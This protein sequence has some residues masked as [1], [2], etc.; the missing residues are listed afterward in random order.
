MRSPMISRLFV[1]L[2]PATMLLMVSMVTAAVPDVS[3]LRRQPTVVDV[4]AD[5][6]PK[7]E[8]LGT[9][10]VR[11]LLGYTRRILH[12]PDGHRLAFF[13]FSSAAEANWLF[14]LDVRDLSVR[15]FAIPNNDI[16]SHGG[17]L[18]S[19]G[20]IYIMP[21]GKD[22]AYR[23]NVE[24][25]DHLTTGVPDGE[26]SWDAFGASNGKIYFGT[27]PNAYLGEFDTKSDECVLRRQV[28]PNKKYTR[29]FS[30]TANGHIRFQGVGPGNTYL[31]Y[32]PETGEVKTVDP[33]SS[34][35]E[36]AAPAKPIPSPPAGDQNLD[37]ILVADGR[38]FAIGFPS[39][40]FF[41]VGDDGAPVL[42]G[43]PK[44]PAEV[45][46]MEHA[47]EGVIGI[48]HFGRV[49]RYDLK[50]G[51]FRH[52]QL[53]NRAPA[54]NGIMFIEAV[55]PRC[56]IGAN[57]SQQN[58]FKIDP[59]TGRID[60]ADHMVA[61]VTGEPMC[62]VGFEGKAYLGIYVSSL[63]SLYDPAR[64]YAFG[65]NPR[66]LIELGEQYKQTRP[67]SAVTDGQ[68]VYI[69]S[70]SAYNELGGALAVIDPRTEKIDVYHH[71]VEDQNLPTLAWDVKTR[72][73]WGGTDR[74]GQ[75]RSHPPT[76]DSSLLYAFDPNER[77]VVATVTPWPGADVTDVKGVADGVLVAASEK[78]IALIDTA[79][80]E[81][82][83][84]GTF[85]VGIPRRVITGSD[86]AA[87]CLSG[88]TLYRWDLP[89]NTLTAVARSPGCTFLTEP[90]PG[91]WC[92]ADN[93]S[94]YRIRLSQE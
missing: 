43:D 24:A 5:T 17:A 25:F 19:D 64:P 4:D 86:G 42:R 12:L 50:T 81:M 71:L 13:T 53:P 88:G 22:R 91:V 58:L 26:Y 21:Y 36:T 1:T 14:L 83:Y 65:E 59:Q 69:S 16:A 7:A 61:R 90:A 89:K 28:V 74:W 84:K 3:P 10:S 20:N 52:Q 33:P 79:T 78:E 23:F 68:R 63:I 32:D 31:D 94:V 27:Y 38:T 15:R 93:R 75:M 76:R 8:M 48:S 92:A 55:T 40:R 77:K 80:R 30:E 37:R 67:R 57:Y 54:G 46:F 60:A 72:R 70:D 73:L 9:P 39:S 29:G 41:E 62:A 47:A 34:S 87:Y 18:G 66:E 44:A 45:W 56:V 11:T 6:L 35:S 2:F 51:E 85:P 82:L 49:F